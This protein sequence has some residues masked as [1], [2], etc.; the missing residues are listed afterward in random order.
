MSAA[1][2]RAIRQAQASVT[3]TRAIVEILILIIMRLEQG[4]KRLHTVSAR[5]SREQATGS[6]VIHHCLPAMT[7]DLFL[8]TFAVAKSGMRGVVDAAL[9]TWTEFEVLGLTRYSSLFTTS[10]TYGAR[11][12]VSRDSSRLACAVVHKGE[13]V[14]VITMLLTCNVS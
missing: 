6:L 7:S 11:V 12:V 4:E 14:H 9:R 10:N 8:A 1:V 5:Q 2:G 3:T 13:I